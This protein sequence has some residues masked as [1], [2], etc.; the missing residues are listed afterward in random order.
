MRNAGRVVAFVGDAAWRLALALV[1]AWL[2][3]RAVGHALAPLALA[4]VFWSLGLAV[5]C[6]D[7][8]AKVSAGAFRAAIEAGR[9]KARRDAAGGD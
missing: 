3:L 6:V 9:L 1:F 8:F 7:L 2:G 4:G 5:L